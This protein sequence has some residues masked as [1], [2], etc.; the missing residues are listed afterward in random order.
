MLRGKPAPGTVT[1]GPSVLPQV[2]AA[3]EAAS[4]GLWMPSETD[5]S[6]KFLKGTALNGPITAD[7]IRAQLGAQHDALMP[8]V[9]CMRKRKAASSASAHTGP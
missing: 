4:A 7:V 3:L 5:A 8:S 6:F 2:Q 9:N 1:P